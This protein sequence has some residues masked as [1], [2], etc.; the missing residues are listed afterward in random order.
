MSTKYPK[1]IGVRVQDPPIP[2]LHF[3]A[4]I[5]IAGQVIVHRIEAPSRARA[6]LQLRCLE[7]H[8]SFE[9]LEEH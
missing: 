6:L 2:A 9:L 4:R 8:A 1:Q 3:T 5:V 7:K